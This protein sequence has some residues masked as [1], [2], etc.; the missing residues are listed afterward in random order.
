MGVCLHPGGDT[1]TIWPLFLYGVSNGF[2]A[3]GLN[4][5]Y[6]DVTLV[7]QRDVQEET[8]YRK[9]VKGLRAG[10][11]VLSVDKQQL[12]VPTSKAA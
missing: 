1:P 8:L 4:V 5:N 3:N 6:E 10:K 2:E 9:V 12:W 11:T 7:G